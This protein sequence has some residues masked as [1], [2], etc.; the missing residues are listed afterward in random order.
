M[1]LGVV[2][3]GGLAAGL[4]G[5]GGIGLAVFAIGGLAIGWQACG[6][7]AIAW[8]VAFG[9]LA[10]ARRAAFGGLAVAQ[11][12]AVGGGGSAAHFNDDAAKATLLDHPLKRGMDWYLS[13]P[14]SSNGLFIFISFLMGLAILRLMYRR[15]VGRE[16][17]T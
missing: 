3:F 10:I 6:G 2:S 7:G 5:F 15:D 17:A 11:E 12:Y 9:G 8:D 1:A 14:V 4:I 16:D 13:N